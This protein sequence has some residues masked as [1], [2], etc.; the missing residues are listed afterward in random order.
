MYE[1]PFCAFEDE[2]A[3]AVAEHLFNFH[4]VEMR[5]RR[6]HQWRHITYASCRCWC[7]SRFN[8]WQQLGAHFM[9]MD[10]RKHFLEGSL[11]VGHEE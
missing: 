6:D 4:A 9:C 8:G 11:G 3:T 2:K 1:C 7:G 5:V 10:I